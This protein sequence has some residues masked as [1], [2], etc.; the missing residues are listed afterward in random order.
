[1][2]RIATILF[3]IIL[4]FG[5]G[6]GGGEGGSSQ[7]PTEMTPPTQPEPPAPPQVSA[8]DVQAASSGNALNAASMVAN[9]DPQFGSVV[10]AS[11]NIADISS[12]FQGQRLT[13]NV[14][15]ERG[16]SII[17]DSADAF[18]DSGVASPAVSLPGRRSRTFGTLNVTN[19]SATLGAVTVD[20]N[21][22]DPNDF[23]S[24]GYW[25]HIEGNIAAGVVNNLV[26]GAF[27]DGEELSLDS[28]PTLPV[29]G[30]AT[31]LGNA[32]GMYV[33]RY[34]TD[35]GAL[36]PSGS[37]EVGELSGVARMTADFGAGTIEGCMGCGAGITLSGVFQNSVTGQTSTF[38]NVTDYNLHLGA[39][40]ISSDGT[41][42][43]NTMTLTSSVVPI[44]RSGGTWGGQFSNITDTDGTPRLVAGA[45]GAGKQ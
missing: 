45:F 22:S 2:T 42:S 7:R 40:P 8:S 6:G 15:R 26:I 4:L 39:A 12:R 31:Y 13:V 14:Q 21:S 36:A 27:V 30:S 32:A 25:L 44:A 34:G 33:A 16:S 23:L 29:S 11:E 5:C 37:T 20:W 19:N 17:L 1:M 35:F 38:S 43:S 28:P 10:M 18:F 3:T 24:G 41:F 9:S